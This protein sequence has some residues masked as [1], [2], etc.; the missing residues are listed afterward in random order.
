MLYASGFIFIIFTTIDCHICKHFAPLHLVM[1]QIVSSV[2]DSLRYD[3]IQP[4]LDEALAYSSKKET[5]DGNSNDDPTMVLI[6]AVSGGCDS[7][8]LFHSVLALIKPERIHKNDNDEAETTKRCQNNT[9]LW[10]NLGIDNAKLKNG[11]FTVPCELHVAHFNHEQRGES[12]DGDED[13]VMKLCI[14]NGIPFHS[15]SWSEGD[16]SVGERSTST[17]STTAMTNED[18]FDHNSN[19]T[20]DQNGSNQESFTQDVARKWRRGKLKELLSNIVLSPNATA[21]SNSDGRWGAILTAHHR[22]DAD[23]TILLKLLRGSHLTNL[24]SMDAR[25]EGFDLLRS[26]HNTDSSSPQSSSNIGYFA[27]PMLNVRKQPVI[28]YLTSS[29]FQW[30]EDESNSSNKYK[31]NKVRNELMPLLSEIAGGD[32]ALQVRVFT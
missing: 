31:R 8:A 21:K 4:H 17:I 23:E 11:S 29:A 22:D 2:R 6:L 27:K 13:F 20:T 25:S 30:R 5:N 18:Y 15:Y 24:R 19:E 9:H 10:I 14:E 3:I 7:I 16:F 12:S 1:L 26:M 28:E 32:R